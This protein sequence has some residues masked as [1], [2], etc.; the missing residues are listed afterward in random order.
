MEI[1]LSVAFVV[2][3]EKGHIYNSIYLCNSTSQILHQIQA[4]STK[5][6]VFN[7]FNSVVM[8]LKSLQHR[9][10]LDLGQPNKNVIVHKSIEKPSY[11][12]VPNN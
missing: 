7:M 2:K 9:N 3:R 12:K 10:N 1:F 8:Y 5:I 4:N 11:N 6:T